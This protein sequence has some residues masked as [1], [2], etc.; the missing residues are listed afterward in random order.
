M[1]P[2]CWQAVVSW[3]VGY[4]L[5]TSMDQDDIPDDGSE[6]IAKGVRT[7]T[8]WRPGVAC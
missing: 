6:H 3:G 7:L 1:I 4:I 8:E 5:L 2:G